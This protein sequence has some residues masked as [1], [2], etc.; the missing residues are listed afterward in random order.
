M[1][2]IVRE[3]NKLTTSN[4]ELCPPKVPKTLLLWSVTNTSSHFTSCLHSYI[5][6]HASKYYFIKHCIYFYMLCCWFFTLNQKIVNKC[7]NDLW[8]KS[9]QINSQL[10]I[11]RIAE[12]KAGTNKL[13]CFCSLFNRALYFII[14]VIHWLFCWVFVLCVGHTNSLNS[15][16]MKLTTL[17]LK[18][19]ETCVCYQLIG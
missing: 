17:H 18:K 10:C 2:Q 13:W 12:R 1:S 11:K 5:L 9:M 14:D 7:L 6:S 16:K 3:K 19:L 15:K 4:H 8:Q